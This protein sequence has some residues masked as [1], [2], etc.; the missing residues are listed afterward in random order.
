MILQQR[1][2]EHYNKELALNKPI[3]IL[4]QQQQNTTARN[5]FIIKKLN[6]NCET[7]QTAS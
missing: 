7:T 4:E 2:Q 6:P 5:Q 1:K 3:R